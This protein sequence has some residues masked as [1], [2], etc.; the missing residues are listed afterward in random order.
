MYYQW[1]SL[2]DRY[3]VIVKVYSCLSKTTVTCRRV[4]ITILVVHIQ[5]QSFSKIYKI[6]IISKVK[7]QG[8]VQ[9]DTSARYPE[10]LSRVWLQFMCCPLLINQVP[11]FGARSKVRTRLN[12]RARL[13]KRARLRIYVDFLTE[14]YRCIS[15]AIYTTGN[16]LIPK[17][18][19]NRD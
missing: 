19:N 16:C 13:E 17:L 15:T 5:I 11:N 1:C 12:I 14:E 10:V 6:Y 7:L 8:V 3:E 9:K 4:T 18:Y 2:N